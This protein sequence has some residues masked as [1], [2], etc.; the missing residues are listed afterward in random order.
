MI[1]VTHT[2]PDIIAAGGCIQVLNHL[3]RGMGQIRF[4]RLFQQHQLL[5][6]IQRRRQSLLI[7]RER[8][9]E[10]E[11]WLTAKPSAI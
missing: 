7:G 2:V 9:R 6:S 11:K 5:R 3:V 1:A 4:S 8:K 10:K